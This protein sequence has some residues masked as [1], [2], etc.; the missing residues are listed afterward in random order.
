[1]TQGEVIAVEGM[2]DGT[3]VTDNNFTVYF[4]SAICAFNHVKALKKRWFHEIDGH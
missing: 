1:M 4:Q 3:T 2:A